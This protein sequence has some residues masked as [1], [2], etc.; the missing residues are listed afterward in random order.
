MTF[1]RLAAAGL[2]AL[3]L[4]GCG[5]LLSVY[6]DDSLITPSGH[7]VTMDAKQRAI[8]S[9]RTRKTDNFG[10]KTQVYRRYCS[11]PAP[12]AFAALSMGSSGDLGLAG[13]KS[14][15]PELRARAALAM[16]E[17][18]SSFERTQT[19]NVLREAMFNTCERYLNGSIDETELMIQ[20]A[21]DQRMIVS[22]LAIEQLT[23]TVRPQP[24]ALIS[25]GASAV[26][27]DPEAVQRWYEAAQGAAARAEEASHTE[28]TAYKALV[29]ADPNKCEESY[30]TATGRTTDEKAAWLKC[31]TAKTKMTDA[32]DALQKANAEVVKLTSLREK[33][34]LG[35][36]ATS[37][38]GGNAIAGKS[39]QMADPASL[40]AV[41]GSVEHIVDE[42]FNFDE[43]EMT[44]VVRLRQVKPT[45]VPADANTHN[46]IRAEG[47]ARILNTDTKAMDAAQADVDAS[48]KLDQKCLDYIDMVHKVDA[49]NAQLAKLHAD[50][51]VR[52]IQLEVV[53][54]YLVADLAGRWPKLRAAMGKDGEAWPATESTMAEAISVLSNATSPVRGKAYE[55]V[56][57]GPSSS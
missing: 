44:C 38:A 32:A 43:F 33:S 10:R 57:Y 54:N 51:A 36:T 55:F 20:A 22:V 30:Y 5:N 34:A 31:T 21:R 25:G 9:S 17:T 15:D 53:G 13:L 12:D 4:T 52:K 24:V 56:W 47:I 26:Y 42:T 35:M 37:G 39:E 45:L 23:R 40:A 2:A 14:Q 11:E 18:A 46:Y 19:V 48:Q 6:R 41:A 7:I 8:L 28:D 16:S 49:S 1:I 50:E 3:T 27:N 29:A